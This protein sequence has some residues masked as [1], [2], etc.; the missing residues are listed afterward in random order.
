MHR[1]MTPDDIRT[2]VADFA[3]AARRAVD[4]GFEGVEVHSANGHLLH[5]F[6]AGNTN[7][8]TDAYG[9]PADTGCASPWR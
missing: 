7:R 9:G 2:T 6:L 4:A 8:R 1:A 5:Q 3:S